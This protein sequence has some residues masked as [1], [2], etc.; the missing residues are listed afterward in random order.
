MHGL[1]NLKNVNSY[2]MLICSEKQFKNFAIMKTTNKM[3]LYRLIY[4]S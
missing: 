3:Q 4:Y 1:P 2:E